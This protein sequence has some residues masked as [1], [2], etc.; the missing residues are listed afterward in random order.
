MAVE[1]QEVQVQL[2]IFHRQAAGL[3]ADLET[4]YSP[5]GEPAGTTE[6]PPSMR[7][8]LARQME[9]MSSAM[10]TADGVGDDASTPDTEITN[11]TRVLPQQ[12]GDYRRSLMEAVASAPPGGCAWRR[13]G[14]TMM[15]GA[16]RSRHRSL[17]RRVLSNR[18]P[19]AFQ[20]P[21]EFQAEATS[22][23]VKDSPYN[24]LLLGSVPAHDP[25]GTDVLLNAPIFWWMMEPEVTKKLVF[26]EALGVTVFNHARL[27]QAML[28]AGF[29]IEE[30]PDGTRG[31]VME[32]EGRHI[33]LGDHQVLI[34]M[35]KDG[36][37]G[38]DRVAQLFAET[39]LALLRDVPKGAG[40]VQV[41]M[42]FQHSPWPMLERLMEKRRRA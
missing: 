27:V 25:N 15:V 10:R 42:S 9:A 2:H 29:E 39:A 22:L 30:H 4:T 28:G 19:E 35:I 34:P 23:L 8:R 16:Y 38:E 20:L 5:G 26:G 13:A 32:K 14:Q 7:D 21:Q 11:D 41:N 3:Q 40:M 31:F 37:T 36:L 24:K 1:G 12:V 6:L 17:S 33:R 18:P